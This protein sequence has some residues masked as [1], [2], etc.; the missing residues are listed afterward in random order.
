MMKENQGDDAP[1]VWHKTKLR[2]PLFEVDLGQAVYHGNYFHLLE[3]AREDFLR[4]LGYPYR[5]FMDQQLHLTV[6]EASCSYRKS[7]HYDDP[8]EVHSGVSWWR[9]RSMAFSQNIYRSEGEKSLVLCTSATLNMV[10][11]RFTGQP[12]ILPAE[13]VDLLKSWVNGDRAG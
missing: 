3:L 5:R 4:E 1:R 6:V 12:T 11:V 13:F 7:L 8:I 10:C 2:V 9:R